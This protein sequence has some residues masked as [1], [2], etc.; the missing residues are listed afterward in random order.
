MQQQQEKYQRYQKGVAQ[1]VSQAVIAGSILAVL[2]LVMVVI[3]L[4]QEG[5]LNRT[6]QWFKLSVWEP[7]WAGV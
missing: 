5:R 2:L 4:V 7:A 6:A 1:G 3:G